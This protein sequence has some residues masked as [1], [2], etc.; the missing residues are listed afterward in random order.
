VELADL[1]EI[2]TQIC[3]PSARIAVMGIGNRLRA[4]DFLGIKVI[5]NLKAKVQNDSVLLLEVETTP[6][7]YFHVIESWNPT[8]LIILD[9]ADFKAEVGSLRLIKR[10]QMADYAI[11]SHRR[12][13][14]LF[15][16]F[17]AF[18]FPDLP[19][20]IIG[21]QPESVDYQIG[22]SEPVQEIIRKISD[23]LANTLA[24]L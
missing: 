23:V 13:L 16:D 1:K 15:L 9:A 2:L 17:L 3:A 4:D 11:S 12:S 19:V 8:H 24:C 20:T 7:D 5:Q 22:I 18:S 14:T 10:E 21:I 6:N